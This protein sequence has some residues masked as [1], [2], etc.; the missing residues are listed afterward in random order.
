M[1]CIVSLPLSPP[2]S[3]PPSL[4][5]LLPS[6]PSPFFLFSPSFLPPFLPRPSLP[7]PS[8]LPPFSLS[9]SSL[10]PDHHAHPSDEPARCTS[11]GCHQC[12]RWAQPRLCP[13]G[14]HDH[15]G[16][17]QP[18]W[19]DRAQP[20]YW[21]QRLKVGGALEDEGRGREEEVE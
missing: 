2:P 16:P 6:L 7:P 8:S 5:P 18:R 17:H 12:S 13:R 19:N 21:A 1:L 9:P 11:A 3:F 10:P 14:H 4:P 15:S 20:S